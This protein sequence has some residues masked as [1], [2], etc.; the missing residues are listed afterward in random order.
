MKTILKSILSIYLEKY[1]RKSILK[2]IICQEHSFLYQLTQNMTT[3]CSL[4]YEVSTR[5]LQVQYMLCT[6]NC[7]CFD[8]QNNLMFTTCA[9]L[10]VF[11]YWT[12]NSTNSMSII[13]WVN[14]CKNERF[15]ERITCKVLIFVLFWLMFYMHQLNYHLI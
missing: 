9:E 13:Y 14:W 11:L 12:R 6:L 2:V 3:N 10:V 7:F 1:I 5:K 8:I 4:K 15:W